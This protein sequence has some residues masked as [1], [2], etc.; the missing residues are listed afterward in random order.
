MA[1]LLKYQ[2]LPVSQMHA[3]ENATVSAVSRL[4]RTP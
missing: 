3:I 4:V 2:E 1:C